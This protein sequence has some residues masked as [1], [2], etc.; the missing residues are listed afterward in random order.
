MKDLNRDQVARHLFDIMNKDRFETHKGWMI[1]TAD[2]WWK[3][4]QLMGW[5]QGYLRLADEIVSK[6]YKP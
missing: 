4:C 5:H 1:C 2:E 3:Y 6:G